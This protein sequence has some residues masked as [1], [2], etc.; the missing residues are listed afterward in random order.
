M[1]AARRP[2]TA[3]RRSTSRAST[4]SR[5][6]YA[7]RDLPA[8]GF[9]F[10]PDIT[11]VDYL[12]REPRFEV[13]FHLVALGVPGFGDTPKRLRVKVARARRRSAHADAVGRVEVR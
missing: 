5:C 9:A 3:C 1:E 2:P 7:L 6:A 8:L 4:S 12:P 13:M 10:A 11:A